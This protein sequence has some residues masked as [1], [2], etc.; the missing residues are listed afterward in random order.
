MERTAG[1]MSKQ[2]SGIRDLLLLMTSLEFVKK[3]W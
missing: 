2:Q 1:G 3:I